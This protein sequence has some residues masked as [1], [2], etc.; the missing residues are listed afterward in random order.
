MGCLASA[1]TAEVV[2][3]FPGPVVVDLAA[4]VIS[5]APLQG[6]AGADQY[7]AAGTGDGFLV[8]TQYRAAVGT[9]SILGR[10]LVGGRITGIIPWQG[11]PASAVG[12]VAATTDPDRILFVRVTLSPPAFILE[13]SSLSSARMLFATSFPLMI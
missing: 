13:I 8:L 4:E 3:D 11:L 1:A 6:A 7:F 12:I 5:G 9:F 2:V 10:Y